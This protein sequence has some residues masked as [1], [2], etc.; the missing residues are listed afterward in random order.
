M[1]IVTKLARPFLNE[2]R[3]ITCD[4]FFTSMKLPN[5]LKNK[6]TTVVGTVNNTRREGLKAI[7][8]IK[9]P[10]YSTS[11]FKNEGL[12]L[13]VYEENLRKMSLS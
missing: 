12:T 7:K 11:I 6:K 1:Y 8:T 13:T 9:L 3:N 4:S 2:R 5:A 10:L